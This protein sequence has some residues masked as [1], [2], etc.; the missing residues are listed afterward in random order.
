MGFVRVRLDQ[1]AAV[2]HPE[3]GHPVTPDP[4]VPYRDDDL[5]VLAYPWMFASDSEQASEAPV[6]QASAAP[7]ERRAARRPR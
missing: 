3:T 7:G 6:E 5:L 1:L 4:R 2:Q